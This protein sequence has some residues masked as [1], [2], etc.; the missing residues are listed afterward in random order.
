MSAKWVNPTDDEDNLYEDITNPASDWTELDK[1]GAL[2]WVTPGLWTIEVKAYSTS[3]TAENA[4]FYGT[5]DAY[6][7][8]SQKTAV[9]FLEP[10]TTSKNNK[11]FIDVTMQD[12]K[13]K[14]E[15]GDKAFK[16]QYEILSG[17]AEATTVV[18]KSDFT[19]KEINT[20]SANITKY[21]ASKDNLDAGFYTVVVYVLNEKDQV[22]GGIRKG[23]LLANGV[24][25][26]VSGHIEP[27]DYADVTINAVYVDVNIE[28]EK[29]SI[30]LNNATKEA[31]VVL[32]LTDNTDFSKVPV[33]KSE[34]DVTY[35]TMVNGVVDSQ[36]SLDKEKTVNDIKLSFDKPGNKSIAVQAIYTS[37][38]KTGVYFT[39]TKSIIV[40]VDPSVFNTTTTTTPE[41]E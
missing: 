37:K 12:I 16:L 36:V 26:T 35:V 15:S 20:P 17:S 3:D 25:A 31:E 9:V 2:G 6:F 24:T 30:T 21:G 41:G 40:K 28:L 32:T 11:I 33:T 39:E 5:I 14:T 19:K 38:T 4:I 22:V 18:S 27:S 1:S 34:F 13:V 29:K 7:S 10:E 8:Q 23:F